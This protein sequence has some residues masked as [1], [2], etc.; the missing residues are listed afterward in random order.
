[1]SLEIPHLQHLMLNSNSY[2]YTPLHMKEDHHLNRSILLFKGLQL[3]GP[4]FI[5]SKIP[6]FL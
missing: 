4:D 1:M 5:F 2:L 3:F 6:L